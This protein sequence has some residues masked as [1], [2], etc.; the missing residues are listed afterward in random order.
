MI[1][2]GDQ[3]DG[4]ATFIKHYYSTPLFLCC[5]DTFDVDAEIA[6]EEKED[7][8]ENIQNSCLATC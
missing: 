6:K 1:S 5:N 3:K 8:K 7:A 2:T 4:V